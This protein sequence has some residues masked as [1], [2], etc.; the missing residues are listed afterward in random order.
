MRRNTVSIPLALLLAVTVA[1]SADAQRAPDTRGIHLGV[2]ANATSIKL[3]ETEFS[4]DER[5]NGYGASIYAG[6]NFTKNLG[7]LFALTAAN[8][9]DSQTEDF[10]VVHA[11]LLGRASFPGSSALVPYLEAG[12]AGV[13]TKYDV[14][15]DEVELDGTGLT[16][17]AG[18]NYF[19]GQYVAVDLG[20]R[21]SAGEFGT[22]KI[23]DRD[24]ETGDG[25]GFNTTRINLGLA[26]Y[27]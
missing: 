23:N 27:P 22:A 20:F 6:Y 12:I 15:G 24:V 19:L 11:D 1:G 4:D 10:G 21:F 9:D 17:G 3:D 26:F 7:L 2:A 13:Y 5:E 14:V 16:L 25:V 18:L 8:I